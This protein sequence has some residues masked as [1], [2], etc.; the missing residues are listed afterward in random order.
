M[1]GEAWRTAQQGLAQCQR[2]ERSRRL[3]HLSE[4]ISLLRQAA[5]L[6]TDPAEAAIISGNLGTALSRLHART[7]VREAL[8][9]SIVLRRRALASGRLGVD[10]RAGWAH[11]LRHALRDRYDLADDRGD[12]DGAIEAG[13][14]MRRLLAAAGSRAKQVAWLSECADDLVECGG[15]GVTLMRGAGVDPG[16]MVVGIGLMRQAVAE[17]EALSAEM[18]MASRRRTAKLEDKLLSLRANLSV[19]LRARYMETSDL[20]DLD[21]AIDLGRS[22]ATSSRRGRGRHGD[23]LNR[24]GISLQTR[25]RRTGEL[26][27]LNEAVDAL[28]VGI[29][30]LAASDPQRASYLSSLG[31]ALQLRSEAAGN[32][33][34]LDEA[35]AVGLAAVDAFV[36]AD[37][38]GVPAGDRTSRSGLLSNV[39]LAYRLRGEPSGDASDL[40]EAVRLARAAVDA[41][42]TDG[43]ARASALHTLGRALLVRARRSANGPAGRGHPNGNGRDLAPD[44]NDGDLASNGNARDL[45]AAIDAL[46]AAARQPEAPRQTRLGAAIMWALAAAPEAAPEADGQTTPGLWTEVADAYETAIDLLDLVAWH[47][48]PRQAREWQLSRLPGLAADAAASALASDDV[49]RALSLLERGRSVLWA[50]QLRMRHGLDQLR[51]ADPGLYRRLAGLGAA[52][53]GDIPAGTGDRGER[54]QRL[55]AEWDDALNQAR[56]LPG[57]QGLLRRVSTDELISAATDAPVVVLNVSAIRSD[58]LI[59]AGGKTSVLPLTG[60]TPGEVRRQALAHSRALDAAARRPHSDP[61]AIEAAEKALLFGLDWI[62][63]HVTGPVLDELARMGLLPGDGGYVR[64]C[65]T[66]LLGLLPLHAAAHDRVTSTYVSTLGGQIAARTGAAANGTTSP[67]EPRLLIIACPRC[68]DSLAWFAWTERMRRPGSSASGSLATPSLR[69]ATRPAG[70]PS[71]PCPGTP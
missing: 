47:G 37:G 35:I 34:D 30:A 22:V 63:E 64:W 10:D 36:E 6:T 57:L 31:L 11:G 4:G 26:T 50:Q 41:A 39:A 43:G 32:T 13:R 51:E 65:P 8:D 18:T 55:A 25:Y 60:I 14:L 59:V 21:E 49:T 58:A 24:L 52:L 23:D 28:R 29:A 44:G 19:A 20:G 5:A 69:A 61:L 12:L 53:A 7:G 71:T 62:A 1:P 3:R 2:F 40:D 68:L 17:L 46:R 54:R 27:D 15:L 9:E 16:T 42:G 38:S 56:A 70:I 66:G 67:G 45:A 33:R 48:L